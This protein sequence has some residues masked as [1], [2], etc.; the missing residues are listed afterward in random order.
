V[1]A[2]LLATALSGCISHARQAETSVNEPSAGVPAR[3]PSGDQ[4]IDTVRAQIASGQTKSP[5]RS[6]IATYLARIAAIDAHGPTLRSVIEINPDASAIAD[7]LDRSVGARGASADR[8]GARS[9]TPPA[10]PDRSGA[11]PSAA[12]RSSVPR[13]ASD[14][15]GTSPGA[16]DGSGTPHGA[17]FGVPVL[18]K[19]NIDTADRMMTTA[20]SLALV[21]SKPAHDAFI[22]TRLRESGAVILGK[23]NL[24]EWANFRS[25]RSSSGWSGRG[26]QTKNPYALDRNPCGS[27]SGSGAA[28][29]A[30]LAVVAVGTETDGS[31][32]CPSSANGI[33]GIKPTVGLV[34]RSGII[35][36]SASQD[37]AGPMA[38]TA[39]D[40]AA[41]L[42]VLAGYDPQDP[43]TAPMKDRPPVDYTR[44]LDTNSLSGVRIGVMRHY[45]GF[46]ERVD[47]VFEQAL[48]ALRARGA[49]LVDPVEIPNADKLDADEQVVLQFEFKDGLNRYLQTRIGSSP[50]T[51]A[52]L[53]HFNE[54]HSATEM[55]HF[56]QEL[57][58]QSNARGDL[59]DLHYLEAHARAH[60]LAGPEGIDAALAKDHLD[61]LIAP[62]M[63]PAWTT[64]FVNGDHFLGGGVSTLPAVAGYPHITVPMGAVDTLPV[65]LS[66]VGPAWSEGK[67]I[68]YAYAFEQA[69]H[70]RRPPTFRATAP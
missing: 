54:A 15:S 31:I 8:S 11:S 35:P 68:S 4:T 27:S 23:T 47:A 53:I 19:D 5:V 18:I 51:L 58:L 64:D 48:A 9:G 49:V 2:A 44:L 38:R 24:S 16:L 45:A 60:R 13:G 65:G 62:T 69:T 57:F 41:L 29:A 7:E 42:T 33:V 66:F 34:S 6:L 3:I 32:V 59:T 20:G 22:V 36:I 56:G 28:I 63:G 17:L 39:T 21:D 40:A 37:T 25:T 30:G 46:H 50:R 55:P 52:D 10:G 14:R 26:G 70:A 12:N 43:A 67:L 1:C 61:V